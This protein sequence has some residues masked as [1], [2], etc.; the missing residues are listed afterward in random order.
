LIIYSCTADGRQS[1]HARTGE[2][3]FFFVKK[4]PEDY[5]TNCRNM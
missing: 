1:P 3:I 5:L 4:S 2:K